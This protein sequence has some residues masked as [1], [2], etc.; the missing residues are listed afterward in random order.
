MRYSNVNVVYIWFKYKDYMLYGGFKLYH[1]LF[2]YK[3]KFQQIV[4]FYSCKIVKSLNHKYDD[5]P[6]L[7]SSK[8]N[9]LPLCQGSKSSD[10]SPICSDPPPILIDQSLK[11][12][13]LRHMYCKDFR[14]TVFIG[15][16][17]EPKLDFRRAL[18]SCLPS[19]R[20]SVGLG[21]EHRLLSWTA[22][23]NQ[24]YL[25]PPS[26]RSWLCPCF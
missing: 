22:A 18:V 14:P 1:V 21:E 4:H 15:T 11:R 23:G 10:P 25:E 3:L 2:N 17:W 6:P 19:P 9:D 24:A 16:N 26:E 12:Q 13:S 5:P 20:G 8:F 7:A